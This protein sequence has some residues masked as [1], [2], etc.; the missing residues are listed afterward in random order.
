MVLKSWT[1]LNKIT[2]HGGGDAVEKE[3]GKT[4]AE[5]KEGQEPEIY[6][7]SLRRLKKHYSFTFARQWW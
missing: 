6:C 2:R 7:F 3:A 5:D 4:E 1:V